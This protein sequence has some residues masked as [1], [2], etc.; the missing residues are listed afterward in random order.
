MDADRHYVLTVS[1]PDGVGLVAAV[2]GLLASWGGWLTEVSNHSDPD[3]QRFFMRN[4]IAASSLPFGIE[5]FRQGFLSLARRHKM[6]FAIRDSS[7]LRRVVI[8]V[9][10]QDHCLVD[11]LH[12][13]RI[14]ELRFDLRGVVSNHPD[15]RAYVEHHGV[16]FHHVP[17]P[18]DADGKAGAF[19]QVEKLLEAETVD[20]VVLARY[21]QVLPPSLCERYAGRILNI[22]HSFLPS[23]AG[24]QPYRQAFE[25]GVKLIGA[26]SHFVTADLDEGPII[27]QDVVRVDHGDTV[28][29]LVRLG[30]DVEKTVL[31]R[32]LRYVLEDRVLVNGNRTVVFR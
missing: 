14:G 28:E 3:T 4:E 1:C 29:D 13:W 30:R 25:R 26:T 6:E 10:R 5:E 20:L 19:A 2:S 17:V 23:F 16:A 11:L 21:M 12:R 24:G 8:L 18:V 32:A 15:T 9:S 31:A 7:V 27:E 22:H